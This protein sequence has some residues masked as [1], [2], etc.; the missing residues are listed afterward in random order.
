MMVML[1]L[2][3]MNPVTKYMGR[4]VVHGKISDAS[5]LFHDYYYRFYYYVAAWPE[6]DSQQL[7]LLPSLLY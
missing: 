7:T 4:D 3:M 6:L 2:E 5:S 1:M